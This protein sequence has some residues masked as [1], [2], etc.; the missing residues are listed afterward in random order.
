MIRCLSIKLKIDSEQSELS[1][2]R[3]PWG[4]KGIYKDRKVPRTTRLIKRRQ[5]L[6]NCSSVPCEIPEVFTLVIV[7]RE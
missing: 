1:F 4:L 3:K 7:L 2:P 6:E 5:Q